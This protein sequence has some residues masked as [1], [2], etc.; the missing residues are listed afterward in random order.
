MKHLLRGATSIVV[1]LFMFVALTVMLSLAGLASVALK[2]ADHETKNMQAFQIAQAIV[3]HRAS[4]TYNSAKLNKGLI[5]GGY[6]D[7]DEL[8]GSLTPGAKGRAE[9]IPL[10]DTTRAWVTSYVEF[11]G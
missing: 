7:Y 3:E 6:Y 10:T 1:V 5:V 9:V 8:A 11:E 4:V 2:T